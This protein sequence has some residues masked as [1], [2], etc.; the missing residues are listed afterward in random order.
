M[1]TFH[2]VIFCTALLLQ[3]PSSRLLLFTEHTRM[4]VQPQ[5][6]LLLQ[7]RLVGPQVVLTM[8]LKVMQSCN[9]IGLQDGLAPDSASSATAH[10]Q[11][12]T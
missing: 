11:H 7:S 2:R 5:Q 4:S 8:Q 9:S 3:H 1:R 6:P 10:R 12:I